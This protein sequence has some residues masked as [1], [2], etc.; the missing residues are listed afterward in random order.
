MISWS[1]WVLMGRVAL[2]AALGFIIGWERENR[3]HPAGDRTYALL[4]LG[5]A[6]FTALGLQV[7]P[8]GADKMVAGLVT[9]V[10]F[11]A[12]G[13]IL[14]SA[15]GEIRGLTTAASMWAVAGVGAV[16]GTGRYLLGVLLAAL[17]LLILV[18]E[19][20]PILSRFVPSR[21]STPPTGDEA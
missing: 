14:R 10:G 1:D 5:A 3:G 7:F 21:R 12:G 4:A 2:A 13:V 20:L 19:Q 18:W 15:A 11:L 6:L 9:G 17:V 16:V 8:A